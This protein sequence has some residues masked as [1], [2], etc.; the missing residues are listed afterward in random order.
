MPRSPWVDS[1]EYLGSDLGLRAA[2][3]DHIRDGERDAHRCLKIKEELLNSL[4][5]FYHLKRKYLLAPYF[6]FV[7]IFNYLQVFFF[8]FDS[9]PFFFF[10]NTSNQSF[11]LLPCQKKMIFG[12]PLIY[13]RSA[14]REG[15][16]AL[17]DVLVRV[18]NISALSSYVLLLN[19]R[20]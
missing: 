17:R 7:L 8:F 13:L 2:C 15:E 3:V 11:F 19:T 18:N 14:G 20:N 5:F 9:P 12:C 6:L 10:L 1:T 4:F 16:V